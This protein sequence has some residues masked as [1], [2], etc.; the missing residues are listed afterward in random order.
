VRNLT[1]VVAP[2]EPDPLGHGDDAER[3]GGQRHG[4]H[5]RRGHHDGG[6]GED[7]GAGGELA[8]PL[9]PEVVTVEHPRAADDAEHERE[10]GHREVAH[11]QQADDDGV[12]VPGPRDGDGGAHHEGLVAHRIEPG[13]DVGGAGSGGVQSTSDEAIEDVGDGGCGEHDEQEQGIG[14]S[15]PHEG[16][17]GQAHH[18]EQ[19]GRIGEDRPQQRRRRRTRRGSGVIDRRHDERIAYRPA[20]RH[21]VVAIALLALTG[22]FDAVTG[23]AA[24]RCTSQAECPAGLTCVEERGACF[25]A[26]EIAGRV[27]GDGFVGDGEICDDGDA[28][29]DTQPDACRTTCALAGCGDGVI[30]SGETCDDGNRVDGDE[31]PFDCKQ[32]VCGDGVVTPPEVCDDENQRS[33]DG[34]RADCLKVEAC[35]DGVV[36]NGEGCD[37][38]NANPDDGCDACV[39]FA[40][41]ATLLTGRGLEGGLARTTALRDPDGVAI[42]SDGTVFIADT[43]QHRVLRIDEAGAITVVAGTGIAGTAG[44]GGP[45]VRAQLT[46]PGPLAL[47]GLGRLFIVDDEGK[48]VQRVEVDGT[49]NRF[50][51]DR[52]APANSGDG[53]VALAAGFNRVIDITVDGPGTVHLLDV[54]RVVRSVGPDGIIRRTVGGGGFSPSDGAV[55]TSVRFASLRR[56]AAAPDGSLLV[57]DASEGRTFVVRDGRLSFLV[58]LGDEAPAEGAVASTVSMPVVSLAADTDG[59]LLCEAG[60]RLWR[61]VDGRLRRQG[62][63]GALDPDATSD[64]LAASF[65]RIFRMS[66]SPG[67]TLMLLSEETHRAWQLRDGV[68]RPFAGTGAAGSVG[69]GGPARH[70]R[71]AQIGKPAVDDDG[72]LIPDAASAAVYRVGAD[73]LLR[74]VLGGGRADAPAPALE[75]GLKT[76]NAVAADGAGGFFVG[77]IGARVVLHVDSAGDARVVAGADEFIFDVPRGAGDGGS[78][79]DARFTALRTIALDP[80]GRLLI[81][82]AF[83]CLLWRVDHDGLIRVIAGLGDFSDT[84]DGGEARLA[85]FGSLNYLAVASDGRIVVA[86]DERIREIALDGTIR[87]I[88]G[89][90]AIPLDD[91]VVLAE[92]QINFLRGIAFDAEDRLLV[93]AGGSLLRVENGR[94]RSVAGGPLSGPIGDGGSALVADIGVAGDV[95]PGVAGELLLVDLTHGRLRRI[96]AQGVIDTIAGDAIRLDVGDFDRA[97]LPLGRALVA[98]GDGLLVGGGIGRL[99]EADL[100]QQ[101]VLVRLGGDDGVA[102][103]TNTPASG[104]DVLG[105][106]GGAVSDGTSV[107]LAETSRHRLLEITL[108]DDPAAWRISHIAGATDTAGHADASGVGARFSSPMGLAL[109]GAGG[110]LVADRGNHV[111]RRVDLATRA[112]TTVVGVPRF[113]GF[114]GDGDA[115]RAA[116]LHAPEAVAVGP[117]AAIYVADTGN[118]RVRRVADNVVTT[119]L[120]DGSPSSSGEGAPSLALPV[121]SPRALFVD[122]SGNLLVTSPTTVRLLGAGDTGVVDGSG[123]ALTIYGR[124]P[125]TGALERSTRCLGDVVQRDGDSSRT[126]VLDSCAGSLIALDRTPGG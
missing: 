48:R 115:A 74:R 51:G 85:G 31:C 103:G 122:A 22:C 108:A 101:Q 39:S 19:V 67:G 126:F 33:G 52:T 47:D 86:G 23:A 90:G 83:D 6:E 73:G 111:I 16:G 57:A 41:T 91:G 80:E 77:D 94:L 72:I 42:G 32:V 116:L 5:R 1:P 99:L 118:H 106:I 78:P 43:G 100:A 56:M 13:A 55:A 11:Q 87:T 38:G 17:E 105:D 44:S 54:A 49:I 95:V 9:R 61:V 96:D 35:G 10:G 50:A 63:D 64:P 26:D 8:A 93:A 75:V 3:R 29:S 65:D 70:A 30:D 124:A 28:N 102:I 88:A 71:L 110:V 79:V 82:D 120:G 109:D 59:P 69:E 89:L 114:G 2:R 107:W 15:P 27:C 53:G 98:R 84:G 58:G 68:L 92:T 125:R 81:L 25:T 20:M 119:I 12:D 24:I 34:C 121:E 62:G 66:A 14:R 37:D 104:V 36:D 60:G 40:W 97:S 113:L 76:P 46:S 112:V 117:D 21:C 7:L 18:G 4:P 45:A 123:L